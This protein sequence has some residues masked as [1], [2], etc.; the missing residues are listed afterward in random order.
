MLFYVWSCVMASVWCACGDSSKKIHARWCRWLGGW[1]FLERVL[2]IQTRSYSL[3]LYNVSKHKASLLAAFTFHFWVLSSSTN[4]AIIIIITMIM[5]MV[6]SSLPQSLWEFTRFI[7][8]M[9][10]ERQVASNS[11][12]KPT[13]LGG[14]STENWLLPSTVTI[15]IYY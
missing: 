4:T 6:L 13:D 15:A 14:E 9:Q 5:F 3:I 7:W 1:L 2:T 12:T 11:Q 10:T 8:P